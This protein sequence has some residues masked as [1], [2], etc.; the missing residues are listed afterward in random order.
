[1]WKEPDSSHKR[2]LLKHGQIILKPIKEGCRTPKRDEPD[3][4]KHLVT[5]TN[6]VHVTR[7]TVDVHHK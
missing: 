7:P 5:N 4:Y 3:H 6:I 2:S 1:M